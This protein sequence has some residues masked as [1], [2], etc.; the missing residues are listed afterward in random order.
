MLRLVR[1]ILWVVVIQSN[2]A[3]ASTSRRP[4]RQWRRRSL[5]PMRAEPMRRLSHEPV[6]GRF[7]AE[8]ARGDP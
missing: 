8:G 6:V 2:Q 5:H 1:R 4:A 3:H 7:C